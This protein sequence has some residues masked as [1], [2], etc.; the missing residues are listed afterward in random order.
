MER[1]Y[2]VLP[3]WGHEIRNDLGKVVSTIEDTLYR[4][5]REKEAE[6]DEEENEI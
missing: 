6:E 1:G 2:I 3:F 5:N 4:R